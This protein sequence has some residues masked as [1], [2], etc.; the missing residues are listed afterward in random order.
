MAGKFEINK[1][2]KIPL[3]QPDIGNGNHLSSRTGRVPR[4][5]SS[6]AEPPRLLRALETPLSSVATLLNLKAQAMDRWS[7]GTVRCT[8][9][10]SADGKRH[11]LR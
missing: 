5:A 11:C 10:A 1:S 6:H 7:L 4:H 8:C 2:K 3:V 9:P